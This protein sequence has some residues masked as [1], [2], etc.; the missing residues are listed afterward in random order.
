MTVYGTLMYSYPTLMST[1]GT[2]SGHC[3]TCVH[4]WDGKITAGEGSDE[5]WSS[6]DRA[7]DVATSGWAL[8]GYRGYPRNSTTQIRLEMRE[9][10]QV[11]AYLQ[12]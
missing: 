12:V 8:C 7:G 6:G 1:Y 3:P 4:V 11:D 9:N 2:F 10:L 5:A